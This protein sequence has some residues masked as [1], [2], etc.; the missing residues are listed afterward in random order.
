MSPPPVAGFLQAGELKYAWQASWIPPPPT[1][2]SPAFPRRQQ[3]ALPSLPPC[4]RLR[5]R[6][7]TAAALPQAATGEPM[8]EEDAEDLVKS[9]DAD[10]NGEIDVDEFIALVR[11]QM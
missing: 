6:V 7:A 10:G 1:P 2:R 11:D 9:I 4:C 5:L 8:T 3:R